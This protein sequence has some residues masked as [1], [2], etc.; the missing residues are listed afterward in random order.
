MADIFREVDEDIRKERYEKLWKRYRWWLLGIT[1][2]LI[3]AVAAYVIIKEQNDA[4]HIDEGRQF[5]AAL[6]ELVAVV[7]TEVDIGFAIVQPQRD[8]REPPGQVVG[9]GPGRVLEPEAAFVGLVKTADRVT[10][11]AV[12]EV[13]VGRDSRVAHGVQD[14]R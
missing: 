10:D 4:R 9:R 14:R 6:G 8:A 12:E 3:I 7:D 2:A 11:P 13:V 5:A 1:L